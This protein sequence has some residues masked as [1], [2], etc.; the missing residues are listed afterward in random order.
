[1][2]NYIASAGYAESCP[3]SSLDLVIQTTENS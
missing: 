1:M 2:F 3:P